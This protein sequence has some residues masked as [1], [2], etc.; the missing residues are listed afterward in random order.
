MKE[1]KEE[2]IVARG[3]VLRAVEMP[4]L[5]ANRSLGHRVF[6]LQCAEFH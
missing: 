6:I 1:K 3:F 5:D 4:V 2:E